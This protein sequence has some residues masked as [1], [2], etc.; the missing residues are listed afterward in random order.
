MVIEWARAHGLPIKVAPGAVQPV[1]TSAFPTPARRP[2]NS[3][4]DTSKLRR[5]FG[6][7]MPPWEAGVQRMLREVYHQ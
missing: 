4:L 6:L 5:A 7:T 1:S 2:L 3:R